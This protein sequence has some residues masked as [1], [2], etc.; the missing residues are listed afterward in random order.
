MVEKKIKQDFL[1][2][3]EVLKKSQLSNSDETTF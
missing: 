3:I 2:V 1:V